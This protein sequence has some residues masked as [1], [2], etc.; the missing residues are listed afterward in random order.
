MILLNIIIFILLFNLLNIF[1]RWIFLFKSEF[2]NIIIFNIIILLNIISL[3]ISLDLLKRWED[4]LFNNL[5]T[6]EHYI[7]LLIQC[8]NNYIWLKEKINLRWRYDMIGQ[9]CY[10]H[11]VT[12][13]HI[14]FLHFLPIG[15]Y[16]PHWFE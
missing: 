14:F 11:V 12:K 16:W 1:F 2:F 3:F 8:L 10:D 15:P 9:S 5:F 7:A 6:E 4:F 13:F